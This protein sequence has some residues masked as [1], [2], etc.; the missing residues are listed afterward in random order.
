MRTRS[1]LRSMVTG[2][3]LGAAFL[4]VVPSAS[5][6]L[7]V[8]AGFTDSLVGSFTA[9]TAVKVLP[10]GDLLVLEKGGTFQRVAANGAV[11]PAGSIA[12]NAECVG[13]ANGACS[14]RRSIRRSPPRARSTSTRRDLRPGGCTNTLSKFTMSGGVLLPTSEQVLIDNIAWTA[15]NHNGGT[16]E[17]GRDGFLYLS[18]GEGADTRAGPESRI[19]RRQDP[20]N[21]DDGAAGAGQSV[22]HRRRARPVCACRSS[23][24]GVRRDLRPRVCATR[25]VPPSI[26]TRRRRGSGSTTSARAPGRRSTTAPP[27]PTT[28]GRSGRGRARSARPPVARRTRTSPSRAL[29]TRGRSARSSSVEP[30]CRT[31]GGVRATT[32]AT[33]SP[34]APRTTCG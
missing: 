31:A 8:P 26:R 17:V 28:A 16:V 3:L 23:G 14:A 4:V 11:S 29:R 22:P 21:H 5:P 1:M 34:T 15:T 2:A 25:S 13:L 9:P 24:R 20:A 7:A 32:A 18:V 10:G 6:A 30:S 33:C 19:A 12:T 27:V